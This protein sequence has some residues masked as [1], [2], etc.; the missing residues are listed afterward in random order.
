[1]DIVTISGAITGLKTITEIAKSISGFSKEYEIK[2]KTM[3][4]ITEIMG[5]QSQMLELQRQYQELLDE[6]K[7][8]KEKIG[9]MED[10]EEEK[11]KY[12]FYRSRSGGCIIKVKEDYKKD[13][14]KK[15]FCPTCFEKN[16]KSHLQP[17]GMY[18][19]YMCSNCKIEIR[20]DDSE[21]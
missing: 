1:M 4:L 21:I 19:H 12:A 17:H 8:L 14:G 10:W 2:E 5:V 18:G 3:Q 11:K 7:S 15:A 20:V 6:N 16:I 13:E 9:T